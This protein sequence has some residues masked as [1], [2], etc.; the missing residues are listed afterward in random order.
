MGT[1][2]SLLGLMFCFLLNELDSS[3]RVCRYPGKAMIQGC[4][5]G[6]LKTDEGRF[7][8]KHY[9]TRRLVTIHKWYRNDFRNIKKKF[10]LLPWPLNSLDLSPIEHIYDVFNQLRSKTPPV[11]IAVINNLLAK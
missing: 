2:G 1:L 5:V 3:I 8:S 7:F 6:K 9:Y 10:P 4:T 11:K